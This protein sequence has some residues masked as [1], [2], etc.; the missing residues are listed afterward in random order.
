MRCDPRHESQTNTR[1]L[2]FSYAL[3]CALP[4]STTSS[5]ASRPFRF[6]PISP[7][8]ILYTRTDIQSGCQSLHFSYLLSAHL[9]R[10]APRPFDSTCL[11]RAALFSIAG[12]CVASTSKN[13]GTSERQR[14]PLLVAYSPHKNTGTVA[15][16]QL[17]RDC[18]RRAAGRSVHGDRSL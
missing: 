9:R 12:D 4:R 18:A 3:R 10:D 7:V 2:H 8:C 17:R 11:C 5:D 16:R 1:H 6:A 13:K 14:L 15:N